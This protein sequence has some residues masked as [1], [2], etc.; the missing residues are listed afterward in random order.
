MGF[1]KPVVE[2]QRLG[3][4]RAGARE[5]ILRRQD[6]VFPISRQRI[7][8]GKAAVGGG[9]TRVLLDCEREILDRLAQTV[10]GSFVPKITPSEIRVVGVRPY[11]FGALQG[12]LFLTAQRGPHLLGDGAGDPV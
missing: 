12:R 3:G 7:S 10:S 1:G 4:G 6:S 2:R 8:V 11:C 5:C 9:E